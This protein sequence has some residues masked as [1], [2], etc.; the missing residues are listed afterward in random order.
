[1]D[2]DAFEIVLEPAWADGTLSL[3]DVEKARDPALTGER[4]V[5][6]LRDFYGWETGA[7]E[8]VGR[9]LADCDVRFVIELSCGAAGRA[10]A[11]SARE[12]A[13]QYVDVSAQL[14]ADGAG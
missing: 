14:L 4:V 8:F 2:D 13:R 10:F 11:R 1:M 6:R 5:V 9:W 3:A 7:A 12:A